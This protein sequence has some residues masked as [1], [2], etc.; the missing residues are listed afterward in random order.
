MVFYKKKFNTPLILLPPH[1]YCHKPSLKIARFVT[2]FH[3]QHQ[4]K[5]HDRGPIDHHYKIT[6]LRMLSLSNSLRLCIPSQLLYHP[7]QL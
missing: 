4:H 6:E 2:E 3:H 7:L 5:D 1:G